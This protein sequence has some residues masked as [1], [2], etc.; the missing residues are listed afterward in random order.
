MRNAVSKRE[1][2]SQT[3]RVN[4]ATLLVANPNPRVPVAGCVRHSKFLSRVLSTDVF[5]PGEISC[6]ASGR[7]TVRYA[8]VCVA[9]AGSCALKRIARS[10]LGR[11]ETAVDSQ[12]RRAHAPFLRTTLRASRMG[13]RRR[14]ETET[15]RSDIFLFFFF[16]FG[17]RET[18]ADVQSRELSASNP[19]RT[20]TAGRSRVRRTLAC[21]TAVNAR[22]RRKRAA[23]FLE[24]YGG[25]VVVVVVSKS[26]CRYNRVSRH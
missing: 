19:T 25:F 7:N 6:G 24:P 4:A 1:S 20:E 12:F 22:T 11:T 13:A 5:R 21:K 8:R 14:R 15:N 9:A 17:S 18:R 3:N 2:S 26:H 16:I 10:P 23:P